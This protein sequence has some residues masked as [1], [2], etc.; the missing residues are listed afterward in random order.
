MRKTREYVRI[1]N[2]GLFKYL[3]GSNFSSI[4]EVTPLF[5]QRLL[6]KSPNLGKHAKEHILE[7]KEENDVQSIR[8]VN[9]AFDNQSFARESRYQGERAARNTMKKMWQEWARNRVEV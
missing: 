1:F 7:L 3:Y 8:I 4:G 2:R 9:D 6:Q 5:F